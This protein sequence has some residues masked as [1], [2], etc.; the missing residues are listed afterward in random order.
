MSWY[1]PEYKASKYAEISRRLDLREY[2][3]AVSQAR[4]A[5]LT[6]LVTRES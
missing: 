2:R 4:E 3:K 6:N 5:G 1:R